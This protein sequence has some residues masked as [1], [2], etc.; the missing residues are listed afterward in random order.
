VSFTNQHITLYHIFSLRCEHKATVYCVS[1]GISKHSFCTN[2]GICI[3][4]IGPD[5][6][7]MGC[8]CPEGYEGS[9][10]QFV[11]GTKPPGYPFMNSPQQSDLEM[12][13]S[14]V[15]LNGGV[16]V[17]ILVLCIC[18]IALGSAFYFRFKRPQLTAIPTNDHLIA[19]D[20]N[21][22]GRDLPLE[23]DGGELIQA[24][25]DKNNNTLS[26]VNASLLA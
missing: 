6:A 18:F 13:Q 15:T 5:S 20:D 9:S 23:A 12:S 3:E 16:I 4:I 14:E 22:D 2:N 8:E 17:G 24:M 10:C 21:C 25:E 7:H 11:K 19:T 1:E 26:K